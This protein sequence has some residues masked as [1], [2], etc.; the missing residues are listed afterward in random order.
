MEQTLDER[1]IN[2]NPL[3]QFRQWFDE[4]V[5]AKILLPEAMTLAT[6]SPEGKPTARVVLY[7]DVDEQGFIFYTNYNSRKGKILSA[8]PFGALVFYWEAL[9]RQIR[10]EGALTKVSPGESDQYFA[11]RP[12]DSQISAL[13]SSQSE[14]VTCRKELERL[15][16]EAVKRYEGKSIPRPAHWGGYRLKPAH[17]E[18]WQGREA[19]LHDR[20][21]YEL[22]RDGT[23]KISRL[24]P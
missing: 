8:N 7:K 4:A 16:A 5:N 10:I 19:R 17:I 2:P 15:A 22:Q 24:A 9:Q 23:W 11:T 12:R 6:A 20:I 13:I 14:V 3:A 1:T 21:L 18:F